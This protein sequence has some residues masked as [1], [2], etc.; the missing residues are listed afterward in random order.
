MSEP[1]IDKSHITREYVAPLPGEPE[2]QPAD[3]IDKAHITNY[4][5]P[6]GP[7][8]RLSA[9][10]LDRGHLGA[11]YVAPLPDPEDEPVPDPAVTAR[12]AIEKEFREHAEL[13]ARERELDRKRAAKSADP[14][15]EGQD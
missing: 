6:R 9:N 4:V 11:L 3:G 2:E 1:E 14:G 13:V 10:E 5:S 7:K 15:N 8:E 12:L